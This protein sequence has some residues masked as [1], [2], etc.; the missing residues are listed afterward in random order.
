MLGSPSG[1]SW[2]YK[3][4][5]GNSVAGLVGFSPYDRF[6]IHIDYLWN[7]RSFEEPQLR[8]YYG[9][10][11]AIGFGTTEFIGS[12]G[13]YIFFSP[14]DSA[15]LG[16]RGAVGIGYEIPR[17][18]VELMLEAAPVFVIAPASGLGLDAGIGARVYF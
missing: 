10:G 1:V 6:R 15:I 5:E 11:G 17:S 12:R 7:T 3:L 9:V 8:L 2:R 4:N 14:S 16:L 18:P 13:K